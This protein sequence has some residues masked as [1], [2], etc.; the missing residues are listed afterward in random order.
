M[1]ACCAMPSLA[2]EICK[3]THALLA[4]LLTYGRAKATFGEV[5]IIVGLSLPLQNAIS[6][7]LNKKVKTST[8]S[9]S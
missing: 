5:D 7:H 3:N 9:S 1:H 6:D 2:D 8:A 4:R